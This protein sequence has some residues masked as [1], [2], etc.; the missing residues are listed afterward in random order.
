MPSHYAGTEEEKRA[1][2]LF[3][4]LMRAA[5][6]VGARVMH[7]TGLGGLTPTQFGVLEALLHLGPLSPCQL[8]AKHLMSRNNL[9]VVIKNL[10][11]DRLIYRVPDPHDRRAHTI[12][13]TDDGRARIEAAFPPHVEAVVEEM[14]ALSPEQQE[15]L[16]ALLRQLG[17]GVESADG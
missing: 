9:S 4:K 3:I 10:E 13:L 16:G 8:A 14:K 12:H 5:D 1:L 17:R 6:S 2:G 7:R 15:Q 11:R